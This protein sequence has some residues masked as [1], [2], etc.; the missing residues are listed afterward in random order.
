MKNVS[1]LL[2]SLALSGC[3]ANEIEPK[4]LPDVS[5]EQLLGSWLCQD[6]SLDATVTATY[7][8]DGRFTMSATFE[9]VIDKSQEPVSLTVKSAGE[10]SISGHQLKSES[11]SNEVVANNQKSNFVAYAIKRKV[12]DSHTSLDDLEFL[13]AN[14]MR[15]ISVNGGKTLDCQLTSA[16]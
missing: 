15:M 8:S 2:V 16:E 14:K 3:A 5:E 13:S 11:S 12:P 4:Q 7:F 10:W 6:D 9:E 1:F